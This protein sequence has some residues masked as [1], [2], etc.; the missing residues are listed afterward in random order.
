M[1]IKKKA[2]RFTAFAIALVL[3][4]ALVPVVPMLASTY[5]I[6]Q[7]ESS[8]AGD[9]TGDFE[10]DIF[11]AHVREI[12]NIPAGIIRDTDVNSIAVLDIVDMGIAS[13]AGIEHF[14]ALTQLQAR[15]NQLTTIDLS[16][17]TAL[18][19]L[20]VE[21][22]QL[23]A[24]DLS[25]NTS[26]RLLFVSVNQLTALDVTNNTA[27]G[28]LTLGGNQV[29]E[30][31]LSNNSALFFL[32][33]SDNLFTTFDVSNNAALRLFNVSHNRL[34]TLDISNNHELRYL[35]THWN[36]FASADDVVGWNIRFDYVG[37]YYVYIEAEAEANV[38]VYQFGFVFTPQRPDEEEDEKEEEPA[39]APNLDTAST[40]A[41]DSIIE[42]VGLGLV[43]QNLQD[44]YAQAATR[45]EF[46]A[47][48]VALY[49]TVTG[50]E[51]TERT[52]FDDTSDIN[53][54][55]MA[56]LGVV[57]GV[58]GG[59]FNPCGTITREQ[60]AVLLA[61]LANAIGQP[62][63]EAAPTFA[64]NAQLSS[65]AVDGVGQIQ[66]AGIM[67]GVGDNTFVPHGSYTREASIITIL[68]LFDF[69][70]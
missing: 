23:T 33:A 29:S 67:T 60:A 34:T 58:G 16:A 12:T 2:K 5:Q 40:W 3:T 4:L 10:C 62:L 51:I 26:I 61:R 6:M 8:A 27:L 63:P 15:Y 52:T 70:N 7:P 28:A 32:N 38:D 53:V 68:R 22:N 48:A 31:D 64:D 66:A 35:R 11:L 30:L 20:N 45:A 54:Q 18:E 41:Q 69:L 19:I 39:T 17:N 9:I 14:T 43:P 13:L 50:R 65:W 36:N 59:N 57:Q 24:L 25:S 49:E 56:G 46:A 42:A 21:H 55:K 47:L 1:E 37:D 44:Q